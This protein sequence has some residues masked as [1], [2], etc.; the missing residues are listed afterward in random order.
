MLDLIIKHGNVI[1]GTSKKSEVTDVGVK[2]GQISGVGDLKSTN[3]R[4]VIEARGLWVTPGFIDVQNHS[5]SYWTLFD[6]PGQESLLKQGI[7]TVVVGQ[8]GSSLAPLPSKEAFK[9]TQKWHSLEG[10]NFNW[11]RF[12][13]YL[14]QLDELPLGINVAHLIGH[15]TIRRGFL[16]DEV[17]NSTDQEIKIMEK[18]VE[19]SFESGAYGL[20]FGL[21]YAHEYDSSFNELLTLAKLT[22]KY[23][24]VVSVH[25]RSQGA[26]VLE[27][28][29][30]VYE[31]A[32]RSSAKF[33]ISHF[34]IHGQKNWHL[35]E[36]ALNRIERMY[37]QG[38]DIKFDTYP[39]ETSWSVLYTYLPKWAY[40][41]GR[42]DLVGR[43][44]DPIQR[45]RMI[46][47]LKEQ[48]SGLSAV[49][50]AH[51]SAAP[52]LVGKSLSDI[53]QSQEKSVEEALINILATTNSEIIVFDP[54][55]DL[56]QVDKLISHPLC[57]ASTDG[58]GFSDKAKLT[59]NLVH[60]RC[61][62]T[63]PKFINTMIGRKSLSPEE[64]I[65]KIT[66]TPADL[67]GMPGKGRIEKGA[68]ADLVVLDPAAIK[69]LADLDNPYQG[70]KGVR[71]VIVNGRVMVSEGVV[72][73]GTRCGQVLRR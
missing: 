28:L 20:S 48:Y 49:K 57:I 11:S 72:A 69:D 61:F 27:A 56:N 2:N 25:L 3:A 37:R 50:V 16:K 68:D 7:T 73:Q 1:T 46:H 34:N 45:K 71:N 21:M 39:Y 70:P 63:M 29:D 9:S 40:E 44:D 10:V 6:Y 67:F 31:L 38:I 33:K 53:A 5:D 18:M 15:S 58:A 17:R 36:D 42:R 4:Q 22:K 47:A 55:L 51:A 24:R 60:P 59:G 62:G 19:E 64:I 23:D 43:L 52:H 32:S 14:E 65:N 41:G 35:F 12:N 30:E 66:K 54:N 8:C 13:E 26:H